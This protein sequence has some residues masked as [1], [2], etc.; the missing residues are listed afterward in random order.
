MDGDD[1]SLPAIRI[2]LGDPSPDSPEPIDVE[3]HVL[4][5]RRLTDWVGIRLAIAKVMRSSLGVIIISAMALAAVLLVQGSSVLS[6][7]G[8]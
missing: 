2:G 8:P 4:A 3:V 5:E 6:G 1:R 7:G